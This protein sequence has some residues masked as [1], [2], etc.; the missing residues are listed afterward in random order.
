MPGGG[1][2]H[3]YLKRPGSEHAPASTVSF[4][5]ETTQTGAVRRDTRN[6]FTKV[7][8]NLSKAV[9]RFVPS[10]LV[11]GG[12][13]VS[14]QEIPRL[15]RASLPG[16]FIWPGARSNTGPA[17]TH[18]VAARLAS[19]PANEA[20]LGSGVTGIQ[21]SLA[22]N[23]AAGQLSGQ[24]NL[25]ARSASPSRSQT[26]VEINQLANRIYEMLVKRL[27]SERQRRGS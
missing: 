8:S 2:P 21:R 26:N 24:S 16:N 9:S 11:V 5:P 6:S 7:E 10:E 12:Q 13:T 14:T 19:L 22:G 15:H 4:F 18:L 3:E 20:L 23:A 25:P 27:A 17:L 1:A